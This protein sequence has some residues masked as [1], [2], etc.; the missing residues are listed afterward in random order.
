MADILKIS[1]EG[2][3]VGRCG[4]P[5]DKSI[6]HRAV[7]FGSIAEGSTHIRNF[8][9]GHDCRAT[10]NIMRAMG[11]RIDEISRTRLEVH[12]VGLDG[13]KEPNDVLDCDNS[14]TTMRLLSGLLAGQVFVS[15]L[16]GTAQIR[17][18]PMA[19]IVDPLRSMG[20]QIFGRQNGRFA[21]LTIIPS[22]LSAIEYDMPVASAQ[23]KS[24]LLLAGLYAHGL[25]VVH[26]PGPARDHTER[27]LKSMGAPVTA[28]G[29]TTHSER[30]HSPLNPLNILVPGDISSAAFLLVGASALPDSNLTIVDVGV[31]ATR[32]GIV[33]ALS[34][35]GARIRRRERPFQGGEP[36]ADLIVSGGG[37]RGLEL[38][39]AQIVTMIDELPVLAV[40]ATQAEGRTVV[41]DAQ[42]LRVKETD[43]IATTVS[44]LKKM[45]ARIQETADGFIV[46]GPTPLKGTTVD[47][48]R[49]H[50]LAMALA[51]AAVIAD[52]ETTIRNAH[53]TADS[54]PGFESTLRALNV[55]VQELEWASDDE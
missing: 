30:P 48:H 8:L 1:S 25:T 43:R 11:V 31:N 3:L 40:A 55:N 4:V 47:S 5:G 10:M 54:F 23:V 18:R 44:E 16:S 6:S 28:L 52:G 7:I 49:D 17:G 20:A 50:R 38:G 12:G 2:P 32:T 41:R 19:R 26:Q 33:D 14:G 13:L 21:P 51:V 45:G 29:N 34:E 46:D 9:D 24:C 53:V 22:R 42:E 36:V 39:G 15:V 27:M 35:M 37:L